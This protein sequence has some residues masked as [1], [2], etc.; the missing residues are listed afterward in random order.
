MIYDRGAISAIRQIEF[1]VR[2]RYKFS[3]MKNQGVI[4]FALV[5]CFGMSCNSKGEAE[6][7][8]AEFRTI[9][10]EYSGDTDKPLATVCFTLKGSADSTKLNFGRV[11]EVDPERINAVGHIIENDK[12]ISTADTLLRKC[13]LFI[14]TGNDVRTAY[15]ITEQEA[16]VA[17]LRKIV[18]IFDKAEE[19]EI[20]RTLNANI[21]RIR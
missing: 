12:N 3:S 4:F 13:Y 2:N 19:A 11:F 20:V 1:C 10:M 7:I 15:F 21:M 9:R 6:P 8:T 17:L 14:L 16:A 18:V 5:F